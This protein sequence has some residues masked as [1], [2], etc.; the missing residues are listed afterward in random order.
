MKEANVDKN[1]SSETISSDGVV[2]DANASS[3][4]SSSIEKGEENDNT[5]AVLYIQMEYCEKKTLGQVIDSKVL[6]RDRL[7]MWRLFRQ[8]VEGVAYF[9]SKGII[10]RDLKV[11]S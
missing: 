11:F 6:V 8:I 3:V 5:N 4:P 1:L 9:H 7:R 2:F 10:H